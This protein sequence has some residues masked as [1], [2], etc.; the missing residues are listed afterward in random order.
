MARAERCQVRHDSTR[1]GRHPWRA[2]EV[3]RVVLVV[4]LVL[5]PAVEGRA[6]TA[7]ESVVMI[8]GER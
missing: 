6:A 7:G 4:A 5:R 1:H 3:A 2:L 8:N